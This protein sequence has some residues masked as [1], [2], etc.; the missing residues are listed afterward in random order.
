MRRS[1]PV[2]VALRWAAALAIGGA[3]AFAQPSAAC[4]LSSDECAGVVR[5]LSQLGESELDRLRRGER[6]LE[7]REIDAGTPARILQVAGA[8]V[9]AAPPAIAWAVIT[10]F[11]SWPRF[12]PHLAQVELAPPVGASASLRLRQ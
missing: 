7:I 5:D 10:D 4:P 6:V 2:F 3:T 8:R 11:R 1:G 12:V 9:V